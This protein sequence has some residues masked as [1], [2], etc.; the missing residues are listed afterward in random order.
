MLR[1]MTL[2]RNDNI[3]LVG[4]PNQ[5]IYG[6]NGSSA[7]LMLKSFMDDY[8]PT[9][10]T[11]SENYRSTKAILALA[12]KI[13][14]KSTS[15]D[16]I[17]LQ[18][19][20]EETSYDNVIQEARS[21][22]KKISDLLSSQI[23]DEIEVPITYANFAVLARNKY[24]LQAVEQALADRSIP[25]YY[26]TTSS[27]IEFNSQSGKAFFLGLLVKA[28]PR[29]NFHLSQLKDLLNLKSTKQS[30]ND[31]LDETPLNSI[32]HA[33]LNCLIMLKDNGDNFKKCLDNIL[34]KIKSKNFTDSED[35]LNNAYEDFTELQQHWHR[36]S[37]VQSDRSLSS[38]RNAMALGQ[39]SIKQQEEGIALST[40][41]TMKGQEKD[42]VF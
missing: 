7:D 15:L 34:D 31:L 29:D 19:I 25:Y 35:E 37:K 33:I 1:S 17:V 2:G 39:T 23:C 21:V 20:C 30:F 12:N 41:H 42:I 18:G 9:V 22:V 3:M 24:V 8:S 10:I 36:Y 40:V 14:P 26:K 6:F 28:N 32:Q 13:I 16:N 11:L 38:F 5:S 4:D 27:G